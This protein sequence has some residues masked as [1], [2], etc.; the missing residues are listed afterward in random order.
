MIIIMNHLCSVSICL[1]VCLSLSLVAC[2]SSLEHFYRKT[3][4]KLYIYMIKVKLS[5]PGHIFLWSR[6]QFL[7]RFRYINKMGLPS[8]CNFF[9]RLLKECHKMFRL[10]NSSRDHPFPLSDLTDENPEL[11]LLLSSTVLYVHRNHKAY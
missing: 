8:S 1:S 9:Y 4:Y 6:T 2:I 5:Q 10:K 7:L 3:R 11:L